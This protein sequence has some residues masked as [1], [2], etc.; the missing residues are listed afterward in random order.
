MLC[1]VLI[2]FGKD[3]IGDQLHA[4]SGCE[5]VIV[6]DSGNV[7]TID[8]LTAN[9]SRFRVGGVVVVVF[10][11]GFIQMVLQLLFRFPSALPDSPDLLRG[12]Q[13][14]MRI[15]ASA[16]PRSFVSVVHK[17]I[18][19]PDALSGKTRPGPDHQAATGPYP[20]LCVHGS[21][22][23][24]GLWTHGTAPGTSWIASR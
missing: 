7:P 5:P 11:V 12:R 8:V 17:G 13:R 24:S 6:L 16:I 18:V 2:P 4:V 21:A 1:A 14:S 19:S 9:R 20:P 23:Y 3:L 22:F 15:L 10:I